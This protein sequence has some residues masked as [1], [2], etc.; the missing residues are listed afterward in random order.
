MPELPEVQTITVQLNTE[1]KGLKLKEIICHSAKAC[2]PNAAGIRASIEGLKC[3]GV[4]RVG[5]M[6]IVDF[7]KYLLQIHLKLTGRL[8]LLGENDGA[9]RWERARLNFEK[10][11]SLRFDDMRL[12]GYLKLI[13]PKDLVGLKASLG[14]DALLVPTLPFFRSIKKSRQAIKKILLNQKVISGVGNIY[15]NEAL[16]K[17]R[18]HPARLGNSI[19]EKEAEKL[20]AAIKQVLKI[21]IKAGGATLVDEMYRDIYNKKG[22]YDKFVLVYDREGLPCP[23]RCGGK[24]Q[25]IQLGGRG[26][27]FC[28]NCQHLEGGWW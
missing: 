14:P 24:V 16:F 23:N 15:A 8:L 7:G 3:L 5:K 12:F 20:L 19:T 26:T 25:K 17:A 9:L 4:N 1:L 10:S 6:I 27:Y 18:I 2:I 28:P 11:K 22:Q 13:K 21:G